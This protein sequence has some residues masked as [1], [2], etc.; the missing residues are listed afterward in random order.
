MERIRTSYEY[1]RLPN[2]G[3]AWS[4]SRYFADPKVADLLR[5]IVDELAV[6]G[7]YVEQLHA[8]SAPDQFELVLPPLPPLEAVDTLLHTR[9]VIAAAAT[10]AGL[11]FTLHPKPF[12]GSCGTASHVHMSI[13]S[14]QGSQPEVYESFYAGILQHMRAIAA[15]TYSNEVSYLRLQDG[16]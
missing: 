9:E 4:V 2:D 10:A 7:I 16:C 1:R 8:E 3:H 5:H 14:P 6:M 11:K 12:E 15:L 13:A